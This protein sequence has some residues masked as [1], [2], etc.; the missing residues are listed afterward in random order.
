MNNKL[1]KRQL[2]A[3]ETKQKILD[4]ANGLIMEREYEEITIAEIAS[5]AGVSIGGIYHYF[6]SKEEL[7]FSSYANFDHRL[8]AY[9]NGKKNTTYLDTVRDLIWYQTSQANRMGPKFRAKE[10]R[11]QLSTHSNYVLNTSR[12]LYSKLLDLIKN[13]ITVGELKDEC[14]A[15]ELT[16]TILRMTRGDLFVWALHDSQEPAELKPMK[17]LEIILDYYKKR[18]KKY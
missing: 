14:D 16:E 8:E 13:A 6:S 5:K 2:Q 10:I 4:V 9:L 12:Y 17:D 11:V 18:N 3:Q 1:T 7:F 15:K